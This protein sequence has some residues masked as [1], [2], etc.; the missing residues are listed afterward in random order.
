MTAHDDELFS[1]HQYYVKEYYMC[2]VGKKRQTIYPTCYTLTKGQRV[3]LFIDVIFQSN[4]ER[5]VFIMYH[6]E[7]ERERGSYHRAFWFHSCDR[8]SRTTARWPAQPA[9]RQPNRREQIELKG[10]PFYFLE[11]A[12]S[13]SLSNVFSGKKNE[14]RDGLDSCKRRARKG[15]NN[16]KMTVTNTYTSYKK[17][18]SW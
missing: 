8:A 4:A 14:Q 10:R 11:R 7:R 17:E 15:K 6:R 3:H 16:P 12:D 18:P 1:L 2:A 9:F 13:K 5:L